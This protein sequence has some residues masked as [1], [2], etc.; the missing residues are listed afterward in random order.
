MPAEAD[1]IDF[2]R[3]GSTQYYHNLVVECVI[4][5]YHGNELKVLLSKLAYIDLHSFPGGFIKLTETISEAAAR[6]LKAR[7]SLDQ[8]YL[9]QFHTFGDNRERLQNWHLRYLPADFVETYGAD[10][11]LLK[12]NIAIGYYALVD[13][14]KVVLQ[15]DFF[16]TSLEWYSVTDLPPL[17]FD[18]QEIMDKALISLRNQIYHQPIGYNLLPEKFT[19]PEIH[20]LYETIL[21]RPLDRRNFAN[22]LMNTGILIKLDEKRNIG[23]H[24]APFLYKFDQEN[25][26]KALEKGIILVM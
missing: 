8:L 21:N 9:Q 1:L 17:A 26:Q 22:K 24:R 5:G 16:S 2:V 20:A 3:N 18:H 23:K 11:W 15:P 10:N 13:F 14:S 19:L 7:T 12:G 4:F 6:N 25:Y